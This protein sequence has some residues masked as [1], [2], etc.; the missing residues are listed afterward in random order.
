MD[1]KSYQYVI[2]GGGLAGASA[3]KGIREVDAEGSILLLGSEQYLPYDRPP[4]TKKLWYG[5]KTVNDVFVHDSVFYTENGVDLALGVE[6]LQIEQSSHSV[7]DGNGRK[8]GYGKLLLATGGTPRTLGIQGSDLWEV[9]YYRYLNDYL[10]I[11]RDATEGRTATIIG[12]GYIGSEI[13]A[14][15]LDTRGVASTMVFPEAYLVQRVY[16]EDLG[17][18]LQQKLEEKGIRVLSRDLP[19]SISRRRGKIITQTKKGERIE[20]D[21][22]I[23]GAGILPSTELAS[24]A[25]LEVD[26]GIVVNELLQ[27]SDPDIYAAGDN[28]NFPFPALGDR[29]RIE[30]WDH[31]L[32][33]GAYAGRNMAGAEQAYDY[34]PYFWSDLLDFGYE[35]VGDISSKLETFADWEEEFQLG[36]IY[37]LQNGRVRGVMTVNI[38]D[39]QEDARA[40][41][42]SGERMT[43][44]DLRGAIR[45]EAKK[46]A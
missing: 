38:Y 44:E 39:R 16:P 25:G 22:V 17:L 37:F 35:A 33:Q 26:N 14:A 4:L 32:N 21:L 19:T 7:V 8:C 41:I 15:M 40:L 2:I 12:G 27:T 3:V 36:V 23:V 46:A 42:R 18:A 9:C 34:I 29:R 1:D 45:S 28:A 43:P 31:A 24:S 5:K 30:H 11:N 20:S 13:A 10:R 6:I